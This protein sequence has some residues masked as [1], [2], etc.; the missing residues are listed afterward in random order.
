MSVTTFLRG[1]KVPLPVLNA[2]LL[3]NNVN[4]SKMICFGI[5]PLY[6]KPDQVTTLL[7]NKL[8]NGD[9]KTRVFVP[10]RASFDFATSAYIAYDWT[11]VLAQRRLG[12]ED[13]ANAPPPGFE[14]L[15]R[16]ILSYADG[17]ESLAHDERYQNAV[18]IV[19][20]DE[21]GYIPPELRQQIG[22]NREL[23]ENM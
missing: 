18:Y 5:P 8:G 15:R 12:P 6:H 21:Q 22:N 23:P 17:A 16:E 14:D 3:A 7:R 11:V 9:T 19:I 10:S 20:T 4:E 2:F 13:F 1:F